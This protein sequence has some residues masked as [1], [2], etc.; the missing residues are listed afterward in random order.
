MRAMTKPSKKRQALA[1][2]IDY[3]L[4]SAVYE[5]TA[6]ILNYGGASANWLVALAIFASLEAVV[7][8]MQWASPGRWALGIVTEP[9][10]GQESKIRDREAWWTAAAGTLLILEGSKNLVRWTQ[11]LPVEPLL[12]SA[13]PEWLAVLAKSALG[14]LNV[15]A[16]LLVLRTNWTGAI[17]GVA[18]LAVE[19]FASLVYRAEFQEWAARAVVARRELQGIPVRDGE[20]QFMQTVLTDVLPLAIGVWLIWLLAIAWRFRS[21]PA[22]APE[23]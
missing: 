6:W 13:S 22:D 19:L 11:G 20:I 7:W 4:F 17:V 1:L 21:E 12:G 18:V 14:A 3:L 5:P 2:Y 8:L 16:G 9:V 10:F 15:L 23:A